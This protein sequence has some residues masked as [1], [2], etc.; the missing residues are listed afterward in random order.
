MTCK[1]SRP[2]WFTPALLALMLGLGV[3]AGHYGGQAWVWWNKD[4]AVQRIDR[5]VLGTDID[6]A[7]ILFS[8]TTC[9]VCDLARTWLTERDIPFRELS[10]DTSAQARSAAE[11][12]GVRVVPTFVIGSTRVNGFRPR[13]LVRVFAA[14]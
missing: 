5:A 4:P 9:P 10:L 2:W 14:K 11:R 6:A 1:R 12:V 7:T 8:T 13:E 3:T